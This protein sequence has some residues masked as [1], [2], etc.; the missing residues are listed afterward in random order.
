MPNR[1]EGFQAKMQSAQSMIS[2]ETASTEAYL[3]E[4][5]RNLTVAS[6]KSLCKNEIVKV[7][8]NKADLIGRLLTH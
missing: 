6:L 2:L 3:L 1:F 4:A 5:L 8:G 7:S